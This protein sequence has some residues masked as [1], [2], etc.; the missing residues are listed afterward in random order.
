MNSR[1]RELDFQIWTLISFE[2]W[3]RAFLDGYP[4]RTKEG[5]DAYE[6]SV[7]G[8]SGLSGVP[9]SNVRPANVHR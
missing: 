6:V 5:S 3:C 1:G 9:D 2:L 8:S 7:T 4:V